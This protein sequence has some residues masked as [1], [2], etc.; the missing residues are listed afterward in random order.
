MNKDI[1]N[2]GVQDFINSKIHTDIMSVLLKK[3]PFSSISPKELAEQIQAKEKCGKKLPTWFNTEKIYY[4]NKLNIEQCSSETTAE[5][6]AQIVDGKSLVDMTGG[7]GVDTYFFSKKIDAVFHCEINEKLSEIV[8]YNFKIL[9][10]NNVHTESMD[11]MDF[12]NGTDQEFDWIFIDPSRRSESKGKVFL[13]SD[14]SPNVVEQ[15]PLLFRKSNHILIKTSP[16]LDISIGLNQLSNVKEIHV[17]A[18]KNEVKELLWVLEKDYEGDV[19]IKTINFTRPKTQTFEF[20]LSEE[21]N[22]LAPHGLPLSYLYEPNAAILK[23]GAFKQIAK[24]FKID[25]LG[26]HSHLYTS[27]NL[28]EF[29]GRTFRIEQ[30]MG[31]SKK[32][33][34]PYL[35]TKANI[36]TRNFP[37]N[38]AKIRKKYRIYD[39]GEVYL[40]FTRLINNKLVVI[41]TTKVTE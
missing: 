14:C 25:K 37:D 2:T 38:V 11:G 15:L 32:E 26:D 1:L 19:K 29:P 24:F 33:L 23:A 6:K 13:L 22:A 10:L 31:Y 17:V 21:K 16:L 39:G 7:F 41:R 3:S 5:Y 9:G 28:I 35:G 12:L 4:P 30:V 34:K 36:T 8:A 18:I 27:A 40:F 20:Y